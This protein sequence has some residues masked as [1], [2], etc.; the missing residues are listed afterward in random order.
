[1]SV[2]DMGNMATLMH[3]NTSFIL[4]RRGPGPGEL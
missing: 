4:I 3:T 2:G 1:M